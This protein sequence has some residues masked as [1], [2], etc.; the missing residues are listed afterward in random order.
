M[1]NNFNFSWKY[2]AKKWKPSSY[3]KIVTENKSILSSQ[4]KRTKYMWWSIPDWMV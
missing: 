4:L 1:R 2:A 3:S